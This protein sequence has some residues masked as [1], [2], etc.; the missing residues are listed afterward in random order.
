M[1]KMIEILAGDGIEYAFDELSINAT[2]T[3]QGDN[4]KIPYYEVWE[5]S[6]NEFDK[7]AAIK[8]EDWKND[9]GWYRYATGSVMWD[10]DAI[11]TVNNHEMVAWKGGRRLDLYDSWRDE[12]EEEKAAFYHSFQEYERMYMP[13]KFTCLTE[14][15]CTEMGASTA[16]NVCALSV[17][18]AK[19]NGITLAELFKTYEG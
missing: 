18:L 12:P 16:T 5:L 10:T 11:F 1:S 13:Y 15:L 4:D 6:R 8:E 9:Y 19:A 17:D 14:Y 3:Y 2:R 7:L